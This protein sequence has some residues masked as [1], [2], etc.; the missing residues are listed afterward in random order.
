[1]KKKHTNGYSTH[2]EESLL[3]NHKWNSQEPY[4]VDKHPKYVHKGI[5]EYTMTM[6][7]A[8]MT[9]GKKT[10]T[11][12]STCAQQAG[13]TGIL[14]LRKLKEVLLATIT[15]LVLENKEKTQSNTE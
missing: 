8:S 14:V 13:Y 10:I 12:T 9:T 3:H 7:S 6:R 2:I 11:N 5:K 15:R 1:M 4:K